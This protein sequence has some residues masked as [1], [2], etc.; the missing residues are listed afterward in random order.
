LDN[1]DVF[2]IKSTDSGKTWGNVI[3]VNDDLTTTHQFFTWMTVD[4][5]TGNL[6]IVFYDRRSYTNTQTD[7]YVARSTDGGETFRNFKVSQTSFSP[8]A[9]VFFG[10]YTCIAAHNGKVYPIWMRMDGTTLT[11]WTAI[12][13]DSTGTTSV[14]EKTERP[15]E[16]QLLQNHPNPFNP[17]T[18]IDFYVGN[19]SHVVLDIIDLMGRKVTTL[20]DDYK[21]A[22]WHSVQ[23]NSSQGDLFQKATG[24]YFC[25][26]QA[27]SYTERRKLLLLK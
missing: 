7:V 13:N 8:N 21:R 5:I 26:M 10:D 1:T 23:W 9:G 4:Q 18:T 12:I 27:G 17:T 15:A 16:F 2:L 20:V 14:A 25:Q 6:Y 22:G 19:A 24:V 11:V 3:K